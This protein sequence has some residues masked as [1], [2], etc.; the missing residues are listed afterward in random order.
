MCQ[1]NTHVVRIAWRQ[2]VIGGF[3]ASPPPT[4]EAYEDEDDDDDADVSND[5]DDGASSS[6]ADN[7]STWDTYPLSLV[8]KK[9]E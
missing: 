9:E 5:K 1:V 2:A 7:M 3:I 6:S 4:L 8:T